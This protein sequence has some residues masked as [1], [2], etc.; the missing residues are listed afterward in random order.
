MTNECCHTVRFCSNSF[1]IILQYQSLYSVVIVACTVCV[2]STR[3]FLLSTSS[4]SSSR[5]NTPIRTDNSGW[6]T[7]IIYFIWPI[8]YSHYIIARTEYQWRRYYSRTWW[9]HFL[10]YWSVATHLL[11]LWV[12]IL[13]WA[14]MFVSC[15]VFCRS[16]SLHQ[17][18]YLSRRVLLNVC[19]CLCVW[20]SAT[21]T[22]CTYNE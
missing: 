20:L 13:P 3:Y 11:G 19:V 18:W 1:N 15:F 6:S 5:T 9:L 22:I 16:R 10:R 12:Q 17:A 2:R 14:W 7:K 4:C 21:V 8:V